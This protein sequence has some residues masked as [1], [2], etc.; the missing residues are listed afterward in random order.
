MTGFDSAYPVSREQIRRFSEQGYLRLGKVFT[1]SEI[2]YI[3]AEL[4][5]AV[6]R[7]YGRLHTTG[8]AGKPYTQMFN[9]W[10][11]S[12]SVRRLTLSQRVGRI[13]AQLLGVSGVRLI[14]DQAL[15]K[16]PG[17]SAS[18][19]HADQHYWPLD[20]DRTCSVWIPLQATSLD[21]GPVAF[22][23]RSHTR[24]DR[25]VR[26]DR[27]LNV[28]ESDAA[29][30]RIIEDRGYPVIRRSYGVGDISVHGGWTFHHAEGNRTDQIRKAFVLHLMTEDARLA[31]PVNP[32]QHGHMD[33]FLWR[34]I[35]VGDM[36]AVPMCPL[37]STSAGAPR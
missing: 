34:G 32:E 33:L 15:F 8:V 18:P 4:S 28:T 31:A 6:A 1:A 23:G 13:A 21:M 17:D 9:V 2:A 24:A 27:P 14:H 19:W 36:L 16:E 25:Q 7:H 20:T 11:D 3:E 37:I 10:V 30:R 12:P 29:I 5:A 35:E 22:A 26:G